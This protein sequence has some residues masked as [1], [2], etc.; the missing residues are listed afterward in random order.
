MVT[1]YSLDSRGSISRRGKWFVSIP[2]CPDGSEGLWKPSSLP[3]NGYHGLLNRGLSRSGVKLTTHF[4]LVPGS[5]IVELYL[6][7]PIHIT[8]NFSKTQYLAFRS[9]NFCNIVTHINYD[10]NSIYNVSE[11][12]FLGLIIDDMLSR[13]QHID[14]VTNK[15]S[16][17]C[18]ARRN[19]KYCH[20]L[21]VYATRI[22]RG[23]SGF[24]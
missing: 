9:T 3:S 20:V 11:T 6:H 15:I 5:R 8:L 21:G 14:M 12:K 7:S 1:G 22:N 2:Q 19:L 23:F 10:Q 13:K 4:H 17:A 24:N 16:S 18:F